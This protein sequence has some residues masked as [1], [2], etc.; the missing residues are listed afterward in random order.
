MIIQT[1][2]NIFKY[3]STITPYSSLTISTKIKT[4]WEKVI[5]INIDEYSI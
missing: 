3:L 1:F 2:G 5:L 4:I